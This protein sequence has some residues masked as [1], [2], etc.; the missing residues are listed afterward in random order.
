MIVPTLLVSIYFTWRMRH[1]SSEL[2]HNIAVT[3]WICA[4]STWMLG[5]F[6]LDDSTRLL[7]KIFFF[8][9]FAVLLFYYIFQLMNRNGSNV[10]KS[11]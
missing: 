11:A 6:F 10:S 8:T 7:A 5:E 3:A 9:G 2:A 4:N 1:D